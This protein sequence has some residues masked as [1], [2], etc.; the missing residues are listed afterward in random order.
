MRFGGA[1]LVT[2]S[3]SRHVELSPLRGGAA[4]LNPGSTDHNVPIDL[5]ENGDMP[6]PAQGK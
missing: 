5:I 4:W 6:A 1:V 2:F 3:T